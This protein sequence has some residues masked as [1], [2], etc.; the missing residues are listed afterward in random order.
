M[1]CRKLV[2]AADYC[3]P[4]RLHPVPNEVLFVGKIIGAK[5]YYCDCLRKFMCRPNVKSNSSLYG[6]LKTR[7]NINSIEFLSGTDVQ[8]NRIYSEQFQPLL[9][10]I[11]IFSC[12]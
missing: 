4:C 7:Q 10:R 3:S 2:M 8:Y 12:F 1:V 11:E 9:F 5:E 6:I